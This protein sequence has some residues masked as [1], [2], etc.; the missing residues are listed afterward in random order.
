MH[1]KFFL[2]WGY[3]LLYVGKECSVCDAYVEKIIGILYEVMR[4]LLA[5]KQPYNCH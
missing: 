2:N 4:Q 1:A 3:V 5:D